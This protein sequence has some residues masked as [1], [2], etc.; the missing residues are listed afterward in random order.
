MRRKMTRKR[1]GSFFGSVFVVNEGIKQGA[2]GEK[3]PSDGD[4]LRALEATAWHELC[5]IGFVDDEIHS[6]LQHDRMPTEEFIRERIE[7]AERRGIALASMTASSYLRCFYVL[8]EIQEGR[9]L[10]YDLEMQPNIEGLSAEEW[11]SI[12]IELGL[13]AHLIGHE[14]NYDIATS[15]F[16][17]NAAKKRLGIETSLAR[18]TIR[19]AIAEGHT[20]S[21]AVKS[22]FDTEPVIDEIDIEIYRD[23]D[24]FGHTTH[25]KFHDLS[26]N[27]MS[28]P[29]KTS[30]IDTLVPQIKKNPRPSTYIS[31]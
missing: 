29:V 5:N 26:N 30:S 24:R 14:L 15:Y 1:T 20:T 2:L 13:H 27:K 31:R 12:G 28:K 10:I 7:N 22:Y 16:Q 19:Y 21:S 17:S 11:I 3:M 9:D 4:W 23:Q 6:W 18:R 25:Y 8:L